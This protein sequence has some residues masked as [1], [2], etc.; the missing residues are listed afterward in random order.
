MRRIAR[1]Q[2]WLWISTVVVTLLLAMGIASFAFPGLT[3]PSEELHLTTRGL[4][5]LVLLFN[6]YTIYQQLQIHRIQ[7]VLSDRVETLG[8]DPLTGLHDRRS[9]EERL[10]AEIS[11]AER[12]THALTILML[13]INGLKIVNDQFGHA[14]GDELIRRFAERLNK[15]IRGSDM[16]VRLGGDEFLVLLPE[17]NLSEVKYVLNRLRGLT[18]NYDEKA[19]AVTFS[20][21]WTD[22]RS[23]ERAEDLLKRAD[24]ALYA[25]KRSARE[26]SEADLVKC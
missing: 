20:A 17:C 4:V 15:A 5:G 12:L 16:A 22:Y 13:D 19:I 24:Q 9:G 11:R 6:L 10:V 14:A 25:D 3:P 21:G 8:K 18:I 2:W 1:R 23:G 7:R 26:R